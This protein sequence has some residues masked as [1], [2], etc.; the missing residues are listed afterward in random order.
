V[1]LLVAV[2]IAGA[3]LLGGGTLRWTPALLPLPAAC[4]WLWWIWRRRPSRRGPALIAVWA[5]WMIVWT[6]IFLM[7]DAALSRYDASALVQRLRDRTGDARPSIYTFG[8]SDPTLSFYNGA[9]AR[10]VHDGSELAAIIAAHERG[11]P[12]VLLVDDS[13]LAQY[14]RRGGEAVDA[15][16]RVGIWQRT[17]TDTTGIYLPAPDAVRSESRPDGPASATVDGQRGADG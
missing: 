6:A 1:I 14:W 17:I 12:L 2:L 3:A 7:E 16:A 9:E 8:F 11:E 10:R 4:L 13:S 15:F 5:A